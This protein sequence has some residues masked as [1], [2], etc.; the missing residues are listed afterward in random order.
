MILICGMLAEN[1]DAD[2]KKTMDRTAAAV[3]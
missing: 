1:R 3:Y 2:V